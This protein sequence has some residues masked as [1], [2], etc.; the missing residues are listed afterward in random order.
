MGLILSIETA[1]LTCS[2]ALGLDGET[3]NVRE[4]RRDHFS[5]AE[6]LGIFVQELFEGQA[7]G[8]Q[9]L[10]AVAVGAGPGSY[11][12]LRI[13]VSTAK[14]L[15]YALDIPLLG[16][17]T[18][19]V[20]AKGFVRERGVLEEGYIIPLL[21]ARRNEVYATVHDNRGELLTSESALELQR[22]SFSDIEERNEL[23]L[24]GSGAS[25]AERLLREIPRARF[26]PDRHP[27]ARDMVPIAE[28]RF[29]EG[30]FEELFAFEPYYL[31]D[32]VPTTPK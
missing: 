7:F 3:L 21:D 13:G 19:R 9:D 23:F 2:T 18:L 4:V 32:F 24:L 12:G 11:T 30:G 31:K 15:A 28:E 27:S 8:V 26:F 10:D 14:A 29:Q 6:E 25:K 5:H 17:R 20:M 1:T 16:L 22:N